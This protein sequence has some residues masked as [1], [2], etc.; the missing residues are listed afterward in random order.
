ML[1]FCHGVVG[2]LVRV[3]YTMKVDGL[4]IICRILRSSSFL[5][6]LHDYKALKSY[7]LMDLDLCIG[8]LFTS[9]PFGLRYTYPRYPKL[10]YMSVYFSMS[11][12]RR[13]IYTMPYRKT[14]F[15]FIEGSSLLVL[16]IWRCGS[17]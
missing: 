17:Q 3:E 11:T 8:L 4:S 14:G 2:K 7:R 16:Q 15:S 6:Y 1:F 5:L 13:E 9:D 12:L 10:C